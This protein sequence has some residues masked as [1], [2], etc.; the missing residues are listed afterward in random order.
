MDIHVAVHNRTNNGTTNQ[1]S[2]LEL[3]L[4]L[5]KLTR[6]HRAS[7]FLNIGYFYENSPDHKTNLCYFKESC[8]N[9]YVTYYVMPILHI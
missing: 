3:I 9:L 2:M 8:S 7:T 4:N 5:M 6:H 1:L